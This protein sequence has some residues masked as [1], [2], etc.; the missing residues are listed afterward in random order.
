MKSSQRHFACQL[1]WLA[2]AGEAGAHDWYTDKIDPVLHSK[3]CG[4]RDCHSLN[5][6]DVR[7]AKGGGYFVRQPVPHYRN[8]PPVGEWFIPKER[9]QTAPDDRY[10]ICEALVPINRFVSP[11]SDVETDYRL[12]WMCFF[13]PMGTSSIRKAGGCRNSNIN[14]LALDSN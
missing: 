14:L 10:H 3:C 9:V 2:L 1:L 6:D 8:D 5:P 11:Y 12:R 4:N 7:S 13:A